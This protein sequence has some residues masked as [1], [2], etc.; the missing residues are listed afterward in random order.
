T[1]RRARAILLGAIALGL[2]C[3]I[4]ASKL[5]VDVD[6]YKLY[7]EQSEVVQ[8]FRFVEEH[9]RKPDT[10]EIELLVPPE[11]ALHEP[12]VANRLAALSMRLASIEG[13]G[14]VRSPLDAM[15]WTNRLLHDDDPR[16]ERIAETAG[17]NAELLTLLAIKDPAGLDRWI[18]PNFR[19]VR[20]SVEADKLPRSERDAI[21]DAVH[22]ALS[23]E[24]GDGWDAR[25]TGSFVVYRDLT[26]EIQRTQLWSF[27]I[28]A[29]VVFVVLTVFLRSLGGTVTGALGWA[30]VGMFPTVLPV[31]VAFGVMGFAGISLDMGTAM[32]AAILIGIAVDDTIH[33]LAEFRRRRELGESA[34]AAIEGSVRRIGQAVITTSVALTLGFFVLIL[35]SWQSISSFG[36]LSGVAILGALA[37]DL[38][39]LP[40]LI[41]VVTRQDR[42]DSDT[43]RVP[44]EAAPPRA[45]RAALSLLIAL[46]VLG[47]AVIASRD[48]A[49]GSAAKVLAC[50]TMPNGVVPL[51]AGSDPRCPLR[52]LDRVVSIEAGSQSVPAL[53]RPAFLEA[54]QTS[55]GAVSLRFERGQSRVLADVPVLTRTRRD[56]FIG[57]AV[58]L[59]GAALLFVFA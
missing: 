43:G 50:R 26:T 27:G 19:R 54:I 20:L 17:G 47:S 48:L 29:A 39:V 12:A 31:V 5:D 1:R 9:L 30:S 14:R 42:V 45:R 4:G 10:L 36:F 33:L 6:E 41:L 53:P 46:P 59:S 28:A 57:W 40:A 11:T 7:G 8:A 37:A 23:A 13:L 2:V 49:T 34:A 55:A 24:L 15:M 16:Y 21:L 3:A 44:S 38:W 52:P 22:V 51:V 25:L 18:S 56:A 32:V 35:S 58:G